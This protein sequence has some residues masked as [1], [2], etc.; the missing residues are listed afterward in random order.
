[1]LDAL[2]VAMLAIFAVV[3]FRR[4]V[5]LEIGSIAG[6]FAGLALAAALWAPAAAYARQWMPNLALSAVI[7][8]A[9][10]FMAGYAVV[11]LAASVLR[12]LVHLLLLG[13]LDGL[14]GAAI[15][16]V[17][18]LFLAELALLLFRMPGMP[19]AWL[20][21]SLLAS[22]F[23]AHQATLLRWVFAP[24]AGQVPLFSSL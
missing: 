20:T 17:K 4:G 10:L 9:L 19:S 8:F 3:G 2:L 23:Q 6:F 11:A 21:G 16:L 7:A 15:G 12:G 5:I 18:G 1:M 24:F 14:L 13:W 22:L